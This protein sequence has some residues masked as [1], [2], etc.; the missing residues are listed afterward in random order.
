[1][2]WFDPKTPLEVLDL[3]LMGEN[4]FQSLQ[5]F[6]RLQPMPTFKRLIVQG[7][8][9]TDLNWDARNNKESWD[10]HRRDICS[11]ILRNWLWAELLGIE[12]LQDYFI[13]G[14]KTRR[15]VANRS[16]RKFL[17]ARRGEGGGNELAGVAAL[18]LMD[19]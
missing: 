18:A 8:D 11:R 7:A 6:V 4:L 16:L 13:C 9:R 2:S 14:K 1:M 19:L 17:E 3:G 10:R 15:A 12:V 5:E